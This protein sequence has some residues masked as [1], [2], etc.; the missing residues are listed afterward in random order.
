MP[1]P[2]TSSALN[3]TP[4]ANPDP[5]GSLR[6]P[7]STDFSTLLAQ[8][9]VDSAWRS[10]ALTCA[11][12]GL[13]PSISPQIDS[14]IA[15]ALLVDLLPYPEH[16]HSR[17]P[18][19]P[20]N[21]LWH[22]QALQGRS[23]AM[24]S[25]AHKDSL[26]ALAGVASPYLPIFI[27]ERIAALGRMGADPKAA[28]ALMRAAFRKSGEEIAAVLALPGCPT[29]GDVHGRGGSALHRASYQG[30]NDIFILL[31]RAATPSDW[32]AKD[33][34]GRTPIELAYQNG[35]LGRSLACARL[36]PW[37]LT[38]ADKRGNTPLHRLAQ[39]LGARASDKDGSYES[40]RQTFA[41]LAAQ[42]GPDCFLTP[43][44]AGHSPVDLAGWTS[45]KDAL[46]RAQ[47]E[48]SREAMNQDSAPAQ[49][50]A[51]SAKFRL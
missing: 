23:A 11:T 49:D 31:A 16:S 32:L 34:Q 1:T 38:Q 29:P 2:R 6:L 36:T 26:Y 12:A 37:H 18:R 48:A 24:S 8:S 10:A 44:L 9:G 22:T 25:V 39:A 41:H 45:L 3:K 30:P 17:A 7:K 15:T 13:P 19:D 35:N 50:K 28:R 51:P 5:L 4:Q 42:L 43:N 46:L 20:A 27:T 14:N 33:D 21:T 40:W 47:A